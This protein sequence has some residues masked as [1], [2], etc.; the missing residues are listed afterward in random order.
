MATSTLVQFL[1]GGEGAD[2]SN[3][4]QTETFYAAGAI[5]AGDFVALDVSQTGPDK[6][7]FIVQAPAAAG[8]GTTI[9]VATETATG[10]AATPAKVRVVIAGYVASAN[11]A[12]GTAAGAALTTTATAGRVGAATYVGDGSG[13]AAVAL[14]N[15]VAVALTLAAANTAE[16]MVIKRF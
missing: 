12:T 6:A 13:A 8:N 9:G 7:L 16:V 10:T 5:T 2:T 3:R 4:R 11:V 14:P 15:V 1:G